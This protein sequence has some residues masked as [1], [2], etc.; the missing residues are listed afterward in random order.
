MTFD[1]GEGWQHIAFPRYHGQPI[2]QALRAALA[3][4]GDE[5][6][7]YDP[8]TN[9]FTPDPYSFPFPPTEH[10]NNTKIQDFINIIKNVK[11]KFQSY[12]SGQTGGILSHLTSNEGYMVRFVRP[13]TLRFAGD[14]L[15]SSLP[16][17]DQ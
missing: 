5:R 3:D 11:G 12:Y 8:V 14:P 6:I 10:Y 15:K 9:T 13:V 4:T 7:E 16:L 2:H 17:I 1:V